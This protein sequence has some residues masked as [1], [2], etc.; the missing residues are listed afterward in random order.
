MSSSSG[1]RIRVR[2]RVVLRYYARTIEHLL[3]RAQDDALM[4]DALSKATFSILA[5]S[6][7]PQE[8]SRRATACAAAQLRAPV[9]RWRDDRG[10][11][12]V[13]ARLERT[14]LTGDARPSRRARDVTRTR[15]PG[16]TRDYMA[17]VEAVARARRQ[18]QP[19]GE[20]DAARPRHRPRH[21]GRQHPASARRRAEADFFV[22]IDMEN[23][24]YTEQTFETFDT[25]WGIGYRNIGVVIQSYLRRSPE[26][27]ERLNALGARVRL[28]KGAY[29]EPTD[30]AFQEKE[31]VDRAF[32]ELMQMLL[33][34]GH[35]PGDCD[36]RS[37]R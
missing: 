4:I 8:D 32:V 7:D 2:D 36:P 29:R 24:P 35:V 5:G 22:R 33:A 28:V 31:E 3:Q 13:R 15:R 16:R 25:L 12:R 19:L 21:G 18:P 6:R 11:D 1:Q 34:R 17:I 26:D 37:R 30:V 9:R 10:S 14:G 23:S 20:A 27:V